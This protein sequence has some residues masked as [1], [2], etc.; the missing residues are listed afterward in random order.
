[1]AGNLQDPIK[2][3]ALSILLLNPNH[4]IFLLEK[5]GTTMMDHGPMKTMMDHSMIKVEEGEFME[6]LRSSL[7]IYKGISNGRI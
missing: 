1:M 3:M 5:L 4:L 6:G 2:P 7:D